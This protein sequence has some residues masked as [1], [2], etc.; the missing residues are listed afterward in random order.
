MQNLDW[1]VKSLRIK[2]TTTKRRKAEKKK[3]EDDKVARAFYRDREIVKG[4]KMLNTEIDSI[5]AQIKELEDAIERNKRNKLKAGL[6]AEQAK[7]KG[8]KS[9]ERELKKLDA[10]LSADQL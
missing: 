10:E 9:A 3:K 2:P 6:K 7:I 4:R 8:I 1:G 5:E